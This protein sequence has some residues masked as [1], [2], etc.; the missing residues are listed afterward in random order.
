M[1]E[2][3]QKYKYQIG[4]VLAII[5]VFAGVAILWEKES[6]KNITQKSQIAGNVELDNL[7]L[8]NQDLK[9]KI[10][11]MKAQSQSGQVQSA[12]NESQSDKININTASVEE[13]DKLPGIGP[14]KAADI[15]KYREANGG[16][17]SIEGINNVKG[18]GDA[19]YSKLSDLI[20]VV[21]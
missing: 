11:E 18:I 9:N 16:F 5:L 2:I 8:E 13:L 1:P 3:F 12:S 21:D 4:A 15:I 10:S 7:K 17:K 6:L 19:T 20:T 14:A